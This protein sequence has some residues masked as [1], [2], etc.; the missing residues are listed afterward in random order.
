MPTGRSVMSPRDTTRCLS[1]ASLSATAARHATTG[2]HQTRPRRVE[3]QRHVRRL[4]GSTAADQTHPPAPAHAPRE[5]STAPWSPRP[6]QR[7]P[8][9]D[10][11][12]RR[13]KTP[14]PA[15]RRTRRTTRPTRVAPT[16]RVHTRGQFI[17]LPASFGHDW[18][19]YEVAASRCDAANL[20]SIWVDT[21][22]LRAMVTTSLSKRVP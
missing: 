16:L 12:R 14:K 3:H 5:T 6:W 4:Y 19:R 11:R 21:T 9:A 15:R 1:A 8:P 2:A 10:N 17:S 20:A 7:E 18:F 22:A 13:L